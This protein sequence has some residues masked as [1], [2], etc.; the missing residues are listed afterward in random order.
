LITGAKYPGVAAV[1]ILTAFATTPAGTP[2]RSRLLVSAAYFSTLRQTDKRFAGN[3]KV[4]FVLNRVP[5]WVWVAIVFL[6]LI[7][8]VPEVRHTVGRI[9]METPKP[10][11][12]EDQPDY[13]EKKY[14]GWAYFSTKEKANRLCTG[15]IFTL[16]GNL[17][18]GFACEWKK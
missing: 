17:N 7:C 5:V 2:R 6:V 14:G 13:I 9:F 18:Y 4:P 8:I 10:P 12:A 11:A 16:T 3:A 1:A 15:K